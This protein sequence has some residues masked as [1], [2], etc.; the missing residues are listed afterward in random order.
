MIKIK[1]VGRVPNAGL[2]VYLNAS[3]VYI[4]TSLSD[5]T[6]LSLLEAMA[7]GLGLVVSDV[8][9]IKEWVGPGNG[10]MIPRK[11]SD[12]VASALDKYYN[13]RG[14]IETHSSE[15]INIAAQR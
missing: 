10:I 5:G 15:N 4:S 1:L 8:P 6:S 2:P 14:L 9:A 12:A 7:C 11:D 3:D 13:N